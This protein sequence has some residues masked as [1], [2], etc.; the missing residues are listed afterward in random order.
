M[1]LMEALGITRASRTR[2][3]EIGRTHFYGGSGPSRILAAM[4]VALRSIGLGLC[5]SHSR[6]LLVRPEAA[7]GE[8]ACAL[9]AIHTAYPHLVDLYQGPH[10]DWVGAGLIASNL[11]QLILLDGVEVD[12]ALAA[13]IVGAPHPVEVIL[14]GE[15]LPPAL[16][17][18]IDLHSEHQCHCQTGIANTALIH[19]D[20]KG[21]STSALGLLLTAVSRILSGEDTRPVSLIQLLKGGAGYSR[22]G[23]YTEDPAIAA[24]QRMTGLVDHHHFG[25]DRVIFKRVPPD[26]PNV[27]RPA[28]YTEAQAGWSLAQKHL[29]SGRYQ[30]VLVDELNVALD[31]ELLGDE[32]EGQRLVRSAMLLKQPDVAFIAT[33]RCW[34]ENP[35]SEQLLGSYQQHIEIRNSH[36]YGCASL[37]A[38]IDW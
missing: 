30:A 9:H 13:A 1:E 4:G 16:A 7:T 34:L 29:L 3:L 19:G 15:Q 14:T 31:L 35:H 10:P 22:V 17:G 27:R 2:N 25:D 5:G 18:S 26:H 36:H 38:G 37:R 11:Y 21:K 8:G 6:V 20:G 28:D 33:G 32:G 23:P 24:L 12:D